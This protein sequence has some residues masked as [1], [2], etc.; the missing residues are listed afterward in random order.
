VSN[1]AHSV[2]CQTT[3]TQLDVS[4]STPESDAWDDAWYIGDTP[5]RLQGG[6]PAVVTLTDGPMVS[7]QAE[8]EAIH[9]GDQIVVVITDGGV[10]LSDQPAADQGVLIAV[11]IT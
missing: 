10:E 11:S 1:T 2:E 3:I 5:T 9:I 4:A 6:D 7:D 8:E